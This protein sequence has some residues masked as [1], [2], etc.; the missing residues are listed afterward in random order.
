MNEVQ[1]LTEAMRAE[2][3]IKIR[4]RMPA[5]RGVLM[6]HSTADLADIANVDQR[7]VQLWVCRFRKY[8]AD[9]LRDAPGRGKSPDV[10]YALIEKLADRLCKK[11]T[12]TP[13]KLRN[14]IRRKTNRRYSMSNMRRI[15]RVFGFSCKTSTTV[16]GNSAGADEV[17]RWQK[18]A[19]AVISRAKRRGFRIAIQ[20]ESIFIRIGED[21]KRLWSRIGDPVEIERS[22]RRDKTVVYGALADDGTR[23]MRLYDKFD[24]PTFVRYLAEARRKWGKVLLIMDNAGQHKTAAAR[25]YLEDHKGE[26]EILCLPVATPKLS[27]IEALWKQAKYRLITAAHYDTLEDLKHTV[28]EY[29]R[30]C[31]IKLD[32]YRY[33]ARCV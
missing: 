15:M 20:D 32:I 22:G 12:P 7:T 11:N 13:R 6:G 17:R 2:K 5:V 24:G 21:G 1:A 28:S 8:G 16:Y 27:A 9:G 10:L 26:I 31:S 30:T 33:L 3:N 14:Q 19:S 25:K 4:D 23:L 29:F 18:D